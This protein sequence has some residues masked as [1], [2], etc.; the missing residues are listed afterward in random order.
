M[1]VFYDE[2]LATGTAR[3]KRAQGYLYVKFMLIYQLN[4]LAP[5]VADV[6]MYAQSL[7][8]SYPST[9]T[10][11]NYLSG[12]KTWTQHHRGDISSF[13][14]P[15]LTTLVKSFVSKSSHIPAQASPLSPVDIK[16]ICAYIDLY[17]RIPKV[18]KAAILIAYA[19]FLR[20]SNVLSPSLTSWG[21]PH[22]L[23]M[24]DIVCDQNTMFLLIRSTKTLR[25]PRPARIEILP[26]DNPSTCP[27]QAW[28]DYIKWGNPCP[29]GPAFVLPS[30]VPLTPPPVV[31]TIQAAL[32][33]SGHP[34]PLSVS[35]HS[36]RR[37]AARAAAA[38]GVDHTHIMS[39]RLWASKSGLAAYLPNSP[40]VVP[41]IIA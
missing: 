5:T 11:K 38:A 28:F 33:H 21:G 32:K 8:N 36:L 20:V 13:E 31:A 4:Y 12:A 18:I 34:D 30:G 41:S 2:A 3:N 14:S 15:E 17:P 22:T 29:L 9:A 23:R 6:S 40:R 39:H 1:R 37:G 19:A 35:F 24:S 16:N 26:T 25:G 27:L 7:A 10:I